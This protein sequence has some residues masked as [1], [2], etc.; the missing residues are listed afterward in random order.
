MIPFVGSMLATTLSTLFS[1]TQE[2]R[3]REWMEEMAGVVQSLIDRVEYLELQ[4]LAA[5]QL[6]HDAAVAAARIAT[7]T[8]SAEKHA[9]LQNAFF[10]VGMG[11]SLDADKRAIFLRYVDELTPSHIRFMRFLDSPTGWFDQYDLHWP[12][13][14]A[15]GL[16]SVVEVA[17]PEW[18]AEEPFLDT[19][20][21][22][23]AARGLIESPGLRTMMTGEG[24]EAQR[25]KPKGRELTAFIS[26]PFA[27]DED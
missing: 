3:T 26:G 21:T 13:V 18:R 5:D 1:A 19:L 4:D 8:S 14:H 11:D 20:V 23:L 17:F 10:D 7:A 22:D 9:A 6:F 25:T 2:N 24:L 15:G 27:P 12:K 16:M